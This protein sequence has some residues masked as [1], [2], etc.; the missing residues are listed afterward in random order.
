MLF[1]WLRNKD[2]RQAR[3]G[4]GRKRSARSAPQSFKPA[5]ESLEDRMLLSAGAL[6][7]TFGLGGVVQTGLTYHVS[8]V[9]STGFRSLAVQPLDGKFLVAGASNGATP[10]FTVARFNADG[11][12]DAA[13][14]TN[15]VASVQFAANSVDHA[16]GVALEANGQIIV[17]GTTTDAAGT[18]ARPQAIAGGMNLASH[19]ER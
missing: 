1:P 17:E 5:L 16:T 13:F 4:M 7:P 18:Q 14:G 9:N 6:D 11:T 3:R 15:G 10:G 12:P 8:D 19:S 2:S